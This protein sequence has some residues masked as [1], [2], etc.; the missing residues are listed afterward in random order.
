[1]N[2]LTRLLG[3]S[4]DTATLDVALRDALAKWEA[5]PAPDLGTAH[6]ETRYVVI[7]TEATGLDLDKDRLLAV[8]AIAVDREQLSPHDSFHA[9]VEPD[10]AAV[11]TSLLAFAGKGPVVVFNAS[12]NRSLLERALDEHLGI[13]PD[14]TWLDLHWLLP[15]L[16]DEHIDRPARLADWMKAFGIE[17]F[18]RHHA[19]GDAW[20]IAQLMLAA[21]ARARALGH[22]TPRTLAELEHSR[23]QLRRHG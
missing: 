6:F 3:N 14:W 10:A 19:L 22:N 12:F 18:Q 5:L 9:A 8:A 16:Y 7:N 21:Q 13:T 23:R 4:A 20:A 1:M 17:T 11:L 2:W 15:A